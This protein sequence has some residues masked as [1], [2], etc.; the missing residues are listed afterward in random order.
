QPVL[1]QTL[2]HRISHLPILSTAMHLYFDKV[3]IPHA[4]HPTINFFGPIVGPQSQILRSIER[5]CLAEIILRGK[6]TNNEGEDG[7]WLPGAHEPMHAFV[8]GPTRESILQARSMIQA[9]IDKVLDDNGLPIPQR[10][11]LLVREVME[12]RDYRTSNNDLTSPDNSHTANSSSGQSL[13]YAQVASKAALD[14]PPKQAPVNKSIPKH[15]IP[16]TRTPN[17]QLEHVAVMA[18]ARKC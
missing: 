18:K 11:P 7:Q 8:M 16:P 17:D 9:I 2:D 13:T 12:V 6:G 15:K 1:P 5:E 10:K 14:P 4:E 3:W